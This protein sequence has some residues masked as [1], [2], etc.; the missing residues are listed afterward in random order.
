[1]TFTMTS[2]LT[3]WT[4]GF[5]QRFAGGWF[6]GFAVA[7]PTSIVATPLVRKIVKKLTTQ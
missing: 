6:L 1:M 5:V 3:G 4:P 7:L 2:I